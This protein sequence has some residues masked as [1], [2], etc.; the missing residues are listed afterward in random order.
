MMRRR[1]VHVALLAAVAILLAI[2]LA[3]VKRAGDGAHAVP[4]PAEPV[5]PE[6]VGG[7][8][9]AV[10][11]RAITSDEALRALEIVGGS[12]R[13][14]GLIGSV[15]WRPLE[16]VLYNQL[17]YDGR[18]TVVLVLDEPVWVEVEEFWEPGGR[19]LAKMWT[20]SIH[21]VVD[22]EKGEVVSVHPSVGRPDRDPV[23]NDDV[24]AEKV[25][26]AKEVALGYEPVGLLKPERRVVLLAI[27]YTDDYPEGAAFFRVFD[28]EREVLVGVNLASMEILRERSGGPIRYRGG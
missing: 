12:E 2:S 15:G 5:K 14:R 23:L 7:V 26:R 25:W 16:E 18:V 27:Y 19:V 28:D 21:L 10:G 6:P 20:E 4:P 9:G 3:L 24:E 11:G 13:V 17:V 1:L 22:L 8:E